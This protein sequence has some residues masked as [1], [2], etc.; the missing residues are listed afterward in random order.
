[1]ELMQFQDLLRKLI[2]SLELFLL[3]ELMLFLVLQLLQ[4]KA[5]SQKMLRVL[6]LLLLHWE[7]LL[8]EGLTD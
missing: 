7:Q 3:N 1:M 8:Y 6:E 2:L 4:E 5:E